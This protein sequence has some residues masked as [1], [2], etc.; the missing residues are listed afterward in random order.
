MTTPDLQALAASIADLVA[1]G[2][3][4]R[5]QGPNSNAILLPE[6]DYATLLKEAHAW[7]RLRQT[8]EVAET[9]SAHALAV[10][11]FGDRST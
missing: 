2:T 3:P 11:A 1:D 10:L 4:K 7:R 6:S 8:G 5:L 9:P